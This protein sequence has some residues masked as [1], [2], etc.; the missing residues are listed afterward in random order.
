MRHVVVLLVI[1]DGSQVVRRF[2]VVVVQRDL[3]D[4]CELALE[5][6]AE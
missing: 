4:V 3:A 5:S 2:Q 1:V 6:K